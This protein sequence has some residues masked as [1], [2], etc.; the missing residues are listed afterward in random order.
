MSMRVLHLASGDGWGG[1]ERVIEIL[2]GGFLRA[3]DL[4]VECLLFN[5]GRLAQVLRTMGA[6]VTVVPES[7]R[8]FASLVRA[9]R[10]AIGAGRPDVVHC[11][12]YKELLLAVLAVGLRGIPIVMTVHGLEP[13]KQ[14]GIK[15]FL[16][17]WGALALGRLFGVRFTAVSTELADR[18]AHSWLGIDAVHVPNSMPVLPESDERPFELRERFGWSRDALV[19]G[20]VGRLETV[21]GP[22]RFVDLARRGSEGARFLIVGGGSMAEGLRTRAEGEDFAERLV[23]AGEVS[24]AV[25]YLR[26]IDVLAIPSRH[27]GMPVVL[28]EAA[29]LRIP[30][31]A[32]AVGDIARVMSAAPSAWVVPPDDLAGFG[33]SLDLVLADLPEARRQAVM[34]ARDV[35]RRFSLGAVTARYRALYSGAPMPTAH[36]LGIGATPAESGDERT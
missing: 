5:E 35:E 17:I 16:S 8:S 22:D 28:L 15:P 10:A 1:A 12:R 13:R 11:H 7:G 20:F 19:V 21:K 14:L 29:S 31:I 4:V 30:V 24:S 9:T 26:Q 32:F 36:G 34:W 6:R 3:E 25:P 2:I 23:F 27:E 33:R 18:L